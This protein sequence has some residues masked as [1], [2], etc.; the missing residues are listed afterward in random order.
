MRGA[1]MAGLS[2][3][4]R[5]SA[6]Q[7]PTQYPA[8]RGGGVTPQKWREVPL[9]GSFWYIWGINAVNYMLETFIKDYTT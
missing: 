3:L 1:Y 7:A 8:K 9:G 2:A 4:L 5:D 6:E